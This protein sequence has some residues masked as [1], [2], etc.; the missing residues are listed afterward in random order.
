MKTLRATQNILKEDPVDGGLVRTLTY[1]QWSLDHHTTG[2]VEMNIAGV[3]IYLR[4][5]SYN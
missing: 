1:R 2:L 5:G 4:F 3:H